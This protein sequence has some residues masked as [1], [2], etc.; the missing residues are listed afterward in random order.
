MVHQNYKVLHVTP[1][2]ADYSGPAAVIEN[3]PLFAGTNITLMRNLVVQ[4]LEAERWAKERPRGY[5][6]IDFC[7]NKKGGILGIEVKSG[8]IKRLR[9]LFRFAIS[10]SNSWLIRIYGGLPKKENIEV[11][12][13]KFTLISLPFYLL[14]RVLDDF[15]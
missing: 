7:L 11:G 3:S 8:T 5:A 4:I 13:K 1:G 15:Q 9:S 2:L 14:P 6:E 12:N 10:I